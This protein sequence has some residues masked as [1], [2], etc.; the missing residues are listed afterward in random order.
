MLKKLRN[1]RFLFSCLVKRDFALKYKRTV[2]GMVWSA[3]SPLFN[4][5]IMWLVMSNFFGSNINHY[6]IYLFSGQIV[7][8][9]FCD[10]TN[11]GMTSLIDN[12]GILTKVCVPKYL[13]LLSKNVSS[14][15]SFVITFVLLLIF[16]LIDGLPITW[17][18]LLLLYPITMLLIFNVGVGLILSALFVFFRDMQYLWGIFT[19]LIMWLSTIFYTIDVFPQRVQDLFMLNPVFLFISYFRSIVIDGAIPSNVI[20]LL[21]A[22]DTAMVVGVGSWFYKRYNHQFLYY[23]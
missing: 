9:Y 15:I 1:N 11:Q 12:A 8:S 4:L 13:F 3:L 5:L 2:L 16:S 23:V 7:Y 22:L 17:E 18:F 20:H 6:A 10:A 14:L 19:Q 21:I